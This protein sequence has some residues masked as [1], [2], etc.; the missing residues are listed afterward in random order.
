MRGGVVAIIAPWS[1][2][3]P[4]A[5]DFDVSQAEGAQ[6]SCRVSTPRA[7]FLINDRSHLGTVIRAEHLQTVR[8]QRVERFNG[9]LPMIPTSLVASHKVFVTTQ[10]AAP[11][12]KLS[13]IGGGCV[14]SIPVH[15]LPRA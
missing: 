10:G 9:C 6:A 4:G 1:S 3:W 13:S 5:Y 7:G 14:D 12:T 8:Y 15:A 11:R 2:A